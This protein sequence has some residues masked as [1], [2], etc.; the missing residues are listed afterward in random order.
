MIRK[1]LFSAA[2]AVCAAVG[3]ATAANADPS[4]YNTLS[5]NCEPVPQSGPTF[6]QQIDTGIR[7]GLAEL[8]DAP[9]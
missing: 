6:T 3:V 2:I 4:W 9:D 7:D 5:C 8:N 1:A